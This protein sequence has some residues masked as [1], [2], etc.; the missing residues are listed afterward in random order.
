M[1][2]RSEDLASKCFLGKHGFDFD[3]FFSYSH[4]D[5]R[6]EGSAE[7]KRWSGELYN[8]LRETLDSYGF[9]PP[10][11]IFFDESRRPDDSL[12][13]TGLIPDGLKQAVGSSALLQIVMS[14]QYLNSRWCREEVATFVE[15]R[16]DPGWNITDLIF[17][18]K[19]L[20]T[21]S[22]GWPEPFGEDFET[23]PIGWYFHERGN[24]L[25]D[26]W[27][28]EGWRHK[29]SDEVHKAFLNMADRIQNRL[30]EIDR[31]LVERAKQKEVVA[32]H[33]EG[34]AKRI[35]LYGRSEHEAEW[36]A[37]LK[38]LEQLNL[39]VRP[40]EPEPLDVDDDAQKREKYARVASNCD[41]M[42]MV[43]ADGINLDC[44]LDVV[45][46]DRRGFIET[47]FR[48]Y[49][50]CAVVDWKGTL[51]I[52]ARVNNFKRFGIDWIDRKGADWPNHVKGWLQES[53]QKVAAQYG[54]GAPP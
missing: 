37:A 10:L 27:M 4:G 13:K 50:P 16:R 31:V 9:R 21:D 3:I 25:P 32:D 49:L 24:Y 38:D 11:R 17:V 43:G 2:D 28:K 54:V 18:A 52:P 45:A 41:A 34:R 6:G 53:S 14:P 5:V 26:G 12:S 23:K 1:S 40:R 47:K 42:V 46:R 30:T 7:L 51:G 48:R 36:Q 19:A 8:A 29:M 20:N 22:L 44:D 35:Y 15:F 33:K 39:E